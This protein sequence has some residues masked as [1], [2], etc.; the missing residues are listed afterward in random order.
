MIKQQLNLSERSRSTTDENNIYGGA[1]IEGMERLD[2][3]LQKKN[4]KHEI[5]Q[6]YFS[7]FV[8]IGGSRRRHR[9]PSPLPTGRNSFVFAYIF[10]EKA[11]ASEVAPLPPSNGNTYIYFPAVSETTGHWNIQWLGSTKEVKCI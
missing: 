9:H 10:D 3:I 11:P 4:A 1:L 5:L 2:Q 7:Y 6:N 8:P